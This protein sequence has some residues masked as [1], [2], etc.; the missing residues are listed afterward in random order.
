VIWCVQGDLRTW[1]FVLRAVLCRVPNSCPPER[2]FNILH[3]CI[4][5]DQLNAFADYKKAW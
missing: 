4:D 5:D 1:A 3:D 2:A